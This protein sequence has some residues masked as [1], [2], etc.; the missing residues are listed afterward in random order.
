ML[1]GQRFLNT[2]RISMIVMTLASKLDLARPLRFLSRV[3]MVNA[4]DDEIVGRFTGKVFAADI[5]A[6]DQE[7]VTYEA[8][9]VELV[10]TG[11]PNVK[12]GSRI[13]QGVLNRMASM[14]ARGATGTEEN[15]MVDFENRLAENLVLGVRQR[16]NAMVC[17]MML[18]DFSYDRLGIKIVGSFGTPADLKVTVLTPWSDATNAT[19]I[20][21]IL[22]LVNYVETTYGQ[23]Y[24][25]VTLCRSDFTNMVKS[26]EFRNL[27]TAYYRA[28]GAVAFPQAVNVGN[29]PLMETIA[30]SLLNMSLE[31][32]DATYNERQ[33]TGTVVRKRVL[34]AG[35]VLLS[36]KSDDSNPMVMDL[37]NGMVTESLVAGLTGNAPE[38]LGGEQFGP[39]GYYTAR[40]DLNPPDVVGWGVARCFPRK[41]IPEATAVLTVA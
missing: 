1:Q 16:Q 20:T 22:N 32:E 9:K 27:A 14:Q 39:I 36:N 30:G 40:A 10:T 31:I 38:G 18:D 24:D 15:A 29:L 17:A 28:G 8:G 37:A 2:A 4:F 7:A 21:N 34:P 33:P 5:I 41:H 23:I 11:I 25:R 19:P 12:L 13:P 6:D 35:K 26:V 3:R